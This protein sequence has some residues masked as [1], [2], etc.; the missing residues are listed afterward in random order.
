MSI[1]QLD[2]RVESC[3][4]PV[5][6]S[7]LLVVPYLIPTFCTFF[8]TCNVLTHSTNL[9]AI[10]TYVFIIIRIH[11]VQHIQI[12]VRLWMDYTCLIGMNQPHLT[13]S[14]TMNDYSWAMNT[15]YW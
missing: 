1:E 11:K 5:V 15:L 4:V 2:Y 10:L 9:L 12:E 3:L 13:I 7:L 8:P 6:Q 14:L